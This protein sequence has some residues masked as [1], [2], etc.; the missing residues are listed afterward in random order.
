MVHRAE[1]VPAVTEVTVEEVD[2]LD[3]DDLFLHKEVW[4]GCEGG[5]DGEVDGIL[6]GT[7][8]T[9]AAGVF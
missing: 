3:F 1:G 9:D 7:A 5:C 2:L 6:A 4:Y 8:L